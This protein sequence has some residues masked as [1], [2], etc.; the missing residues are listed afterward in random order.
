MSRIRNIVALLAAALVLSALPSAPV[1][2]QGQPQA[3]TAQTPQTRDPGALSTFTAA[4][5]GAVNTA[6]QSGYNASRVTC[7]FRQSTNLLS[8]TVFKIQNKDAASGQYYDLISSSAI[9][10][11]T[12]ATPISAGAGLPSSANL[13]IGLP[14]ARTWRVVTTISNSGGTATVTGTVGCSV[15]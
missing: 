2:S 1:Y 6:D 14:I 7:V 10:S 8:S 9:T 12:A 13:S 11:S 15:Q 3:I 4:A 5:A